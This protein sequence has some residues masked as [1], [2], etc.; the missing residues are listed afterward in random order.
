MVKVATIFSTEILHS[1]W[2]YNCFHNPSTLPV[3][4]S[5]IFCLSE[6]SVFMLNSNKPWVFGSVFV[7]CA[8]QRIVELS[9]LTILRFKGFIY[10]IHIFFSSM[11]SQILIQAENYYIYVQTDNSQLLYW[12]K[13]GLTHT[14][15]TDSLKKAVL[16]VFRVSITFHSC[17]NLREILKTK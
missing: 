7:S 9:G 11:D 10:L 13:S 4:P 17:Q 15:N 1:L 12:N 16:D 5:V 2:K 6:C 8:W 3:L 14:E